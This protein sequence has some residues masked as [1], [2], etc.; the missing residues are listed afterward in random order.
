MIANTFNAIFS[1]M[2]LCSGKTW[3]TGYKSA[4]L[5]A[6]PVEQSRNIIKPLIHG[7]VALT[8]LRLLPI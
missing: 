8:Q 2:R 7:V 1:S 4:S 6:G 3:G 5:R